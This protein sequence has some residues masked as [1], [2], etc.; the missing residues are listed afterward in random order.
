VGTWIEISSNVD[1]QWLK[2]DRSLC[3]GVDEN[4]YKRTYNCNAEGDYK[5]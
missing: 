4:L 1:L 5:I 2:Q 3:G